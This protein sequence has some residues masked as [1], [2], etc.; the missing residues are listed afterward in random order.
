MTH[1]TN[2]KVLTS[3]VEY[4]LHLVQVRREEIRR[5]ISEF[6]R[7]PVSVS[8]TRQDCVAE[9]S[10]KVIIDNDGLNA[11]K[12]EVSL[13][14]S[15]LLALSMSNMNAWRESDWFFFFNDA[16]PSYIRYVRTGL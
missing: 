8:I 2:L 11:T 15:P 10:N 16:R 3:F 1:Q 13:A 5:Y 6:A 9:K 14:P 7:T 12:E 4:R